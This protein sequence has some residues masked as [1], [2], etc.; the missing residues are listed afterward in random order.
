M[1]IEKT[2][3]VVLDTGTYAATVSAITPADGK[4]G[5]QLE[6]M[7]RLDDG[8]PMK[9]W[10]STSLSAKSKL[11]LWTRAI[12]GD[13]PEMLDTE[14]LVGRPCRLSVLIKVG[15]DGNEYNRVDAVLAPRAGQKARLAPEPEPV[16]EIPF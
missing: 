2:E 9:A 15:D 13:I 16:E 3:Y 5:P 10:T 4:F 11:G 1:R 12:L 7:F 14:D 6:W 8:S